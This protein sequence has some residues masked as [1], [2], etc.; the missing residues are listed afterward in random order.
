M[1][2]IYAPSP[3]VRTHYPVCVCCVCV[4]SDTDAVFGHRTSDYGLPATGAG[5]P[6]DD[7]VCVCVCSC[8]CVVP[9]CPCVPTLLFIP[10]RTQTRY[11]NSTTAF[12]FSL[13]FRVF[14]VPLLRECVCAC[15]CMRLPQMWIAMGRREA[16]LRPL[17]PPLLT[18]Q[19]LQSLSHQTRPQRR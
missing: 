11:E 7:G 4:V 13:F 19:K 15:A 18:S 5:A 3:S 17:S 10:L 1:L 14:A 2:R 6:A 16:H 12:R 8:L 9:V